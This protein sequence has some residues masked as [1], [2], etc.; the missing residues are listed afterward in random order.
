MKNACSGAPE[1]NDI[2]RKEPPYKHVTLPNGN[3]SIG[4]EQNSISKEHTTNKTSR[5]T[6]ASKESCSGDNEEEKKTKTLKE[7]R[8]CL[9]PVRT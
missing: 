7:S 1:E 5:R 2:L 4:A 9:P 6:V 3:K 8:N